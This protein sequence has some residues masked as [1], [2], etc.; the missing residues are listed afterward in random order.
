MTFLNFFFLKHFET[1]LSR[2]RLMYANKQLN[3][4]NIFT[5]D[6]HVNI[7]CLEL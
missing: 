7:I 5:H 3:M 1:F 4:P 6:V 2:L